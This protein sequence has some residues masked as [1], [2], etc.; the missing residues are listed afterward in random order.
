MIW[1]RMG[2]WKSVAILNIWLGSIAFRLG[3][4]EQA[5]SLW[6]EAVQRLA[7]VNY[8]DKRDWALD[9]LGGIAYL[10]GD[11]VTGQQILAGLPLL[12]D[13]I[14]HFG[15]F[16]AALCM[17]DFHLVREY[18]QTVLRWY[19]T[20]PVESSY[21]QLR[22]FLQHPIDMFLMAII[23]LAHEGEWEW[24]VEM[25]ALQRAG[26]YK[27]PMHHLRRWVL[28]AQ[29]CDD[30]ERHLDA[31]TFNRAWQRGEKLKIQT[32]IVRLLAYLDAESITAQAEANDG[33]D[34]PLTARELEVLALVAQGCSNRQIAEELFIT[35]GTV[36]RYVYDICQKLDAQN[37][38]HAVAKARE[39]GLIS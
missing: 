20:H 19:V 37:R 24:A 25:L 1:R 14:P 5:K 2:D 6:E 17:G 3:D 38:T 18:L 7:E 13:E 39:L 31:D 29:V 22:L 23:L 8:P 36:K 21:M 10:E 28:L 11:H 4:F 12:S 27:I 33:L 34:D 15:P 35:V 30:L 32:E 26:E 9:M 16:V